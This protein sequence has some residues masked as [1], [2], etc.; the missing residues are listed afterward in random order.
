[1]SDSHDIVSG[2]IDNLLLAQDRAQRE[3]L[4]S[5][6][7]QNRAVEQI[8]RTLEQMALQFLKDYFQPRGYTVTKAVGDLPDGKSLFEISAELNSHLDDERG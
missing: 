2:D 8:D 5:T 7:T 3:E 1:M 6:I 4:H